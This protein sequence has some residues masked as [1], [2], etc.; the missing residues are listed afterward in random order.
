MDTM[1]DD[2][3]KIDGHHFD[4]RIHDGTV[5]VHNPA[6]GHHCTFRVKTVRDTRGPTDGRKPSTLIGKR[7]VSLL[8]GQDNDDDGS[9]TGFGFVNE[10][11][12]ISVWRMKRGVAKP[13]GYEESDFEKFARI[14]QSPALFAGRLEYLAAL[15]CRR[16]GRKLT[17]P[18]SVTSGY[19]PEC[20]KKVLGL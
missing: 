16:C 13:S 8:S 4:I 17:V 14:L 5:T 11:G 18:T 1:T 12:T 19:G 7:I 10:D 15:S 9:Y 3:I 6:T 20:I 2:T